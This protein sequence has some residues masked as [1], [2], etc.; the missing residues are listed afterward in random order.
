MHHTTEKKQKDLLNKIRKSAETLGALNFSEDDSESSDHDFLIQTGLADAVAG[1]FDYDPDQVIF[2]F[3]YC[4]ISCGV[5]PD[6]RL[7][8]L[9]DALRNEC[10]IN[11]GSQ[12]DDDEK[13]RD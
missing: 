9:L 2:W 4:L 13:G 1:I 7:D 12:I 5:A 10:D 8:A 3:G 11:I 6:E